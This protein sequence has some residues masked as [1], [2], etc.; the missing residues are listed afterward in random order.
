MLSSNRKPGK[1]EQQDILLRREIIK[2][3]NA[4][5]TYGVDN[6]LVDFRE[7]M[8][9]GRQHVRRLKREMRISSKRRRKHKAT[10]NSSHNYPL[11]PNRLHGLKVNA[12]N[13]VWV[14]DITYIEGWLYMAT[15]KDRFT[16]EVVGF[17]TRKRITTE[18]A[19]RAL[20][21]R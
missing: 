2:A 3:H 18:L 9:C 21:M 19:Q 10:T 5:P 7:Y 11:A 1:R 8:V 17:A 12:P 14:S 4:T 6:I 16:H 15:F 13:Q 20:S